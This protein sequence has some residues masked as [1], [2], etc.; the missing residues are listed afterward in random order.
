MVA[1]DPHPRTT[2]IILARALKL[3]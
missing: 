1:N 2:I 3:T